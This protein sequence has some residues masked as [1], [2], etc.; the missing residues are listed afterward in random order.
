MGNEGQNDLAA[1]VEGLHDCK[2]QF[3]E[4]VHVKD[5]FEDQTA[6]EGEV[7]VFDIEG[8]PDATICYAW[9]SQVNGSD[10]RKFYAVLHKP[11]VDS[12]LAA[13]RAAFMADY[14][15]VTE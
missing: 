3:R 12:P 13:V 9:S 6:W 4:S 8:N 10:N 1:C 2:A 11:P 5:V 14:K 15:A 7:Y